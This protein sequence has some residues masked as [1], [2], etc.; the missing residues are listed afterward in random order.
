MKLANNISCLWISVVKNLNERYKSCISLCRRLTD[1]LNHFFSDKQRFVDE[2]NSVTAEKLIYNHAVE[3]VS[4]DGHFQ[5]CCMIERVGNIGVLFVYQVQS[6]A[7]DEMFQQTEDIAYRYNKAS[8]LLEGL[9]KIL[10]DPADIDNVTK[11]AWTSFISLWLFIKRSWNEM[12]LTSFLFVFVLYRQGKRGPEDLSFV[13]LHRDPV[14]IKSMICKI[15][16]SA[17]TPGTIIFSNPRE[18]KSLVF[19]L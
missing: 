6:A 12:R 7:L 18:D 14:W 10:Q 3:M 19:V 11:C 1:K 9:S 4:M 16:A 15:F 2:I 13:L 5:L 17:L 8:M